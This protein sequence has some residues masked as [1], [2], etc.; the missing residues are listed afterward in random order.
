MKLLVN[1]E[2]TERCPTDGGDAE[3]CCSSYCCIPLHFPLSC[4]NQPKSLI[5]S[6]G[7]ARWI[8]NHNSSLGMWG[9]PNDWIS[10][11]G[12]SLGPDIL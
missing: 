9:R 8:G 4:I 12:L 6:K 10:F 2:A 11:R 5:A 3:A 1:T 7:E